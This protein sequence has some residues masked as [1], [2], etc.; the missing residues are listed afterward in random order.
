MSVRKINDN[1]YIDVRFKRYRYRKKSPENSRAG[2]K[3]YEALVTRQLLKEIDP[4]K[5][6]EEKVVINFETFAWEWVEKYVRVNSKP[7]GVAGKTS[8]LKNHLNPF[9]GKMKLDSIS[10]F[11]VEEYKAYAQSKGLQNKTINGHISALSTCLTYAIEWG[12][13]EESD[14]PRIKRLK[15]PTLEFDFLTF[16]ESEVLIDKADE[17]W[18]DMIIFALHTGMRYG[19]IRAIEWTDVNWEKKVLTVKRSIYRSTLGNTKSDKI[20]YIPIS[21][22]LY[23]I[24]SS[25]KKARGYIF[26][27]PDGSFL[28]E[29]KPRRALRKLVDSTEFSRSNGRRIAWHALRHTF[30]SHLAMKGAPLS[31]I[32]QLLGHSSITTTMRYSHLSASTLEDTVGLLGDNNSGQYMGNE[33]ETV[34]KLTHALGVLNLQFT[35]KNKTKTES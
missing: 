5:Q 6:E 22:T 23:S 18:K 27:N 19:E 8:I 28:E 30:A 21:P 12:R 3:A 13:I 4:F 14:K 11:K 20:R 24:L 1:C 31:A 17:Q 32:Q 34:K 26:A 25:Q 16:D 2:A 10:S 29:D 15:L 9:F 33:L 35:A 7:S